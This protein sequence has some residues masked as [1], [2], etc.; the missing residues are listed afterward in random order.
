M[1]KEEK[2]QDAK[3][4]QCTRS[5]RAGGKRRWIKSAAAVLL[6]FFLG[7]SAG[8]QIADRESGSAGIATFSVKDMETQ[9]FVPFE[10]ILKLDGYEK[11]G[12]IGD[13]SVSYVKK[14]P[15]IS[16]RLNRGLTELTKNE[17]TFSVES[18][19]V[20]IDNLLYIK[21]KTLE[22]IL[23]REISRDSKGQYKLSEQEQA[24]HG[25]VSKELPLIAHAGGGILEEKGSGELVQRTYTNSREAFI[26]SYDRGYRVIE[27]DFQL[28]T[29]GVL[30]GL[31][32][33]DKYDGPLSSMEWSKQKINKRY[34]T[35]TLPD[36]LKE[37]TVNTDLYLVL[38]MK[39]YE[40]EDAKVVKQYQ[41]IYEQALN[42]GGQQ[43]VDRL[44][45]QIY[46]Q[47]EYALIKEV[48][49]WKSII[50]TLYRSDKIPDED[51]I[52]FVKGKEDICVVTVLKRR[53]SE[54]FCALLHDAGK[55][56]YT[57][58]IND[59]DGLYEYMNEGVD[60]FYTDT[61]T[62]AAYQ[63]RYF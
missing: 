40:W 34:T 54:D 2:V 8:F 48:Y 23:D 14:S 28:S 58:T 30:C 35:L 56:V 38:D 61:M 22:G 27:M 32:N 50:Y 49:D 7:V 47:S 53:V 1:K 45:P 10:E 19:V 20:K 6:A 15:E 52:S 55:I 57:H 24:A 26:S 39:S 62:P 42:L 33:W 43:L 16:I 9:D 18:S 5:S 17:Y 41:D 4:C 3:S 60:G 29:D 12:L 31:H 25:W 21:R 13:I 59:I 36:V 44:I 63:A 51:I 46:E 37:M 11:K